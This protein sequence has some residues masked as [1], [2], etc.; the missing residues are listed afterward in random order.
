MAELLRTDGTVQTVTPADGK[1]FSLQELQ[2]FV[3]GY[4]ELV[5]YDPD[6]ANIAICNEEGKIY[7]LP[8][9]PAATRRARLWPRDYAVGD[10]LFCK[11]SD[12]E[13]EEDDQDT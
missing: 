6:P 1:H 5:C 2:G 9:N 10:W 8:H 3:G 11:R 7:D 12:L 13:S 4:I